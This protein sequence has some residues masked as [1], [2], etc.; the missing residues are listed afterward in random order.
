MEKQFLFPSNACADHYFNL[1]I[2]EPKFKALHST[3]R[4]NYAAALQ[5]DAQQLLNTMLKSGLT[6]EILVDSKAKQAYVNYPL[7]LQKASE[8]L[9]S[10]HYMYP[11][12]QARK[13][14]FEGFTQKNPQ[15]RKQCFFKALELQPDMP[16]AYLQLISAYS[17]AEMDSAEYYANK[18]MDAVPSWILP[19]IDLAATYYIKAKD[20]VKA[21]M[22]LEKAYQ[23][24]SGSLLVWYR[25]GVFYNAIRKFDKASYWFEKALMRTGDEICFPCA[26][27]GLG[28]AYFRL[29]RNEDA[30]TQINKA[31][32]LDSTNYKYYGT[33]GNIY[34]EM[35]NYDNAE[36]NY[37]KAMRLQPSDPVIQYNL[38]KMYLKL[39]KYDAS[40][41]MLLKAIAMDTSD[42]RFIGELA[43]LYQEKNLF[44][45]AEQ[46]YIK[47]I[48]LNEKV[49]Y[50]FASLA[51]VYFKQQRYDEANA[52]AIKAITLDPKYTPALITLAQLSCINKQIDKAFEYLESALQSD[53][54]TFDQIEKDETLQILRNQNDRWEAM[55]EYMNGKLIK[56]RE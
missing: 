52:Q 9:G 38:G 26:H 22:T 51:G 16:H 49:P 36:N 54:K 30:L 45:K 56:E 12:L 34:G 47:S 23:L 1:L 29:G 25:K 55:K 32:G 7:Y 6:K 27:L 39:K 46:A 33:L 21:E 48:R 44:D 5:D 17:P 4:R 13:Y 24:D 28:T 37:L 18:A 53:P 43:G 2:Q 14:F 19:Y 3:M 20:P 31:I 8:L 35:G 10:N 50:S 11:V 41:K 40:E 15:E 42:Y